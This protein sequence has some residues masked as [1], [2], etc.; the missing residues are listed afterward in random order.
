M[1]TNWIFYLFIAIVLIAYLRWSHGKG[2]TTQRILKFFGVLMIASFMGIAGQIGMKYLDDFTG[3]TRQADIDRTVQSLTRSPIV[4][5]VLDDNPAAGEKVRRAVEDYWSRN[6]SQRDPS[7][8]AR[9]GDEIRSEY[10]LP[11]FRNSDD[12]SALAT[13]ESMKELALYLRAHNTT[14]C[15]QLAKGDIK[16]TNDLDQVGAEKYKAVTTT[17]EVAYRTGKSSPRRNQSLTDEAFVQ[18]LTEGGFNEADLALLARIDKASAD[19]GCAALIKLYSAPA[20]LPLAKGGALA[21]H[22]LASIP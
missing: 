15:F 4:Q 19:D 3:N 6:P 1:K 16:S 21:R 7:A 2:T 5:A 8:L 20:R 14:Q 10:I 11:A 22:F 18:L 13:A 17:E 12:L 9:L